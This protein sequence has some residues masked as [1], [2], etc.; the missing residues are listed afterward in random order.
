MA[1]E[2]H[3]D[4]IRRKIARE[5]TYF[6]K[7]HKVFNDI[8]KKV[9]IKP[10]FKALF[11]YKYPKLTLLLAS[12]IFAYMVFSD[13]YM[14]GFLSRLNEMS[15]LGVFFGGLL[16]AFGFTSPFAVGIFLAI[17]PPN[18]FLAAIIGGI[19][20]LISDMAIFHIIKISFQ[21]E[22][23]RIKKHV[24]MRSFNSALEWT[25]GKK[26]KSYIA[27]IFAGIMIASPL[28][29]EA[30]ITILSGL[31]KIKPTTLAILSF[32]LNTI[33]ILVILAAPL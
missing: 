15:Y 31:T 16:F 10:F 23:N 9:L 5:R 28:P 7:S 29:D 33:G 27:W 1:K 2:R 17:N 13:P 12:M 8:L 14:A 24:V 21:K 19:G 18:I 4:K 32:A 30:G 3:Y 25:I 20:A 6:E 22:F 26:L 11:G